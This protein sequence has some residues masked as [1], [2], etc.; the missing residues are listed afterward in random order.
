[1]KSTIILILL[2]CMT[3]AFAQND[4]LLTPEQLKEDADFYFKTLYEKHPDP[5]YYYSLNE[6]EDKK[7]EIYAQLN[8][9]LTHEQFAWIIGEINSYVGFPE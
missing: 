4:Q 9:P 3:K 8:K 1:M 6:F 5:Y 7:N 2:M